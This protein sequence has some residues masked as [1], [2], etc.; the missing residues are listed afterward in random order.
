[1]VLKACSDSISTRSIY[2]VFVVIVLF[3][4]SACVGVQPVPE[5]ETDL[6]RLPSPEIIEKPDSQDNAPDSRMMASHSLI[7]EGYQLLKKN[8]YDGAIRILERAV[9]LNPSD[10]PGYFYLAEAWLGKKN[11]NLASQ[12]NDLAAMYLRSDPTWSQRAKSQKKR[13]N[14]GVK[15]I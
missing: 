13:I 7:L 11:F 4:L 5:K 1:M 2:I 12:F 9:G 15:G 8:D 14:R 3:T 6:G 10:G